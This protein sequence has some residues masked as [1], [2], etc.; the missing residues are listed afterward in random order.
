MEFAFGVLKLVFV[1]FMLNY[2][3]NSKIRVKFPK[4]SLLQ[5]V[6]G[7][8]D[9]ADAMFLEPCRAIDTFD[10]KLAYIILVI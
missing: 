2:Q 5:E 10:P 6:G 3:V 4:W 8:L 7:S 1:V 9:A